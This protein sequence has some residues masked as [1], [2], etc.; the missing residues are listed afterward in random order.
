MV[1]AGSAGGRLADVE[2]PPEEQPASAS[3]ATASVNMP[4][5]GVRRFMI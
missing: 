3:P 5:A 1:T 4:S 2:L